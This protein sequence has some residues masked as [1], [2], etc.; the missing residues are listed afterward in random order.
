MDGALAGKALDGH[1]RAAAA[2]CA[3][4][5]R[6][7]RWQLVLDAAPAL[8][9]ELET[10]LALPEQRELL[11]ALTMSAAE[12]G[13]FDISLDAARSLNALAARSGVAGEMLRA[14]FTLGASLE[15]IGDSW[16]AERVMAE[17]LDFPG[18]PE[19][20]RLRAHN[21]LTAILIGRFHRT[22]ELLGDETPQLTLG[23]AREH[24][25]RALALVQ[26]HPDPVAEVAIT[27]NLG[28]VLLHLG[29]LREAK[30]LL[31]RGE[32][33]ALQ[34]GHDSHRWRLLCSQAEWQV[35]AGEPAAGLAVAERV[36][37]E[38]AG[39]PPPQTLIRAR[40]AAYLACKALGRADAALQHFEQAERLE[41]ERTT[42]QLRAQSQLFVT[43]IEA[44]RSH[45]EAQR[46]H[47]R[48]Q[49]LAHRAEHDA[50]TTLANRHQLERRL[51]E[52]LHAAQRDEAPL[53]LAMIDIDHFKQ[54][55]DAHGHSAGDAVLA[56][57][58]QVLRE[59]ARASDLIVRLGGEEF[60]VVYPGM[61]LATA[62]KVCERLRL[63]V[64][65]R[66]WEG[67]PG[68][69]RISVSIGLTAAP[70]HSAELIERA[71]AALYAAKR[72]GRNRVRVL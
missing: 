29:H 48:A 71:D 39:A 8:L 5:F 30:V 64:L 13:R 23:R 16:Q 14:A 54:I 67:A 36:L 56:G 44:E 38:S 6:H 68:D 41:R 60:L 12:L 2:A 63:C 17:A 58:A 15:R 69:L 47:V 57:L 22:R 55:N 18:A 21:G 46:Q 20:D 25:E 3:D 72:E 53:T 61:P 66:C 9:A 42:S 27:G 43:R 26:R 24:A 45:A 34:I 51:P 49:E 50:L 65:Q 70:P 40:H 32:A 11:F 59:H 19:R 52:M 31:A 28:E 4:D 37:A 35:A 33:L 7:G 1:L 62:E 10:L